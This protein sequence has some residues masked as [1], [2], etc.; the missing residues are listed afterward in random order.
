MSLDDL[1]KE[2]STVCIV[3]MGLTSPLAPWDNEDVEIWRINEAYKLD[4][5]Y[6]RKTRADR[7]FQLHQPWDYTRKMNRNDPHGGHYEWL[8]QEHPFPIYMQ[9][10]YVDI[11]SSVR[12]PLEEICGTFNL[13]RH[14]CWFRNSICY[15]V[16]FAIYEGFER[17]E[18]YGWSLSSNTERAYEKPAAVFWLGMAKGMGIDIYLTPGDDLLGWGKR[19]YAFEDVPAI[20]RMHCESRSWRANQKAMHAQRFMREHPGDR[21]ARDNF[22]EARGE[23]L[24]W[25]QMMDELDDVMDPRGTFDKDDDNG[26]TTR[27]D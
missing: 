2:K 25:E 10:K 24:A 14:T 22:F 27:E 8:K 26:G 15:Q 16:A 17:I 21:D 12:Y 19:L 23:Q 7:W 1:R 5:Y 18:M 4:E 3:G 11:P 6:E 9:K 20:N 13:N